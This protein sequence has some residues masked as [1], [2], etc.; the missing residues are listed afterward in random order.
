[1]PAKILSI[2]GDEAEVDFGGAIRKT[3]VSMVDAKVGEYVII[4]AGFAIQKVDEEEA[5]ETLQLWNEF[6]DSSEEA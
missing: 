4:H 5:K 1:M 2:D 3:N 6:L